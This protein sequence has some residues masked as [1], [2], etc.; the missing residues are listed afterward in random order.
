MHIANSAVR[1]SV[2]RAAIAGDVFV[3]GPARERPEIGT[4]LDLIAGGWLVVG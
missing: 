1:A 3:A 2:N 4:A